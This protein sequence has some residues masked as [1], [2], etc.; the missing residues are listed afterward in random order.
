MALVADRAHNL[1][2]QGD[3]DRVFTELP[4]GLIDL[5]SA[6]EKYGVG[7]QTIHNWINRGHLSTHGRLRARARGGGYLLLLE[8]EVR[9]RATAPKRKG[10]RPKLTD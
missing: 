3:A 7:V 8:S 1:A 4:E 5:P 6:A 10:G 9:D 2:Q